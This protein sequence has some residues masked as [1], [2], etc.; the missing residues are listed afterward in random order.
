MTEALLEVRDLAKHFPVTRGLLRGK[1]IGAV[2]AVDG[3]SFRI[4]PGETFAIVGESGCGKT[5]LANLILSLVPPTHGDILLHG[6]SIARFSPAELMLY[7]K[8]VTAVF[9][10]PYGALNPRMRIGDVITEPMAIHGYARRARQQRL[11]E[12]LRAVGLSA[13]SARRFPHEFSGGQRQRVGIARAL[14]LQPPLVVLDEPVS[15]LDVSIRSQILNLLK[16]LQA[17]FGISYLLISHDLAT[18]EHMSDWIGVMYLGKLVEIG[19][20]K[21]TCRQ[22]RHPYTAT[23]VAAA[24]P[25]GRTPPWTLPIMGE[26]PHGLDIPSGCAFHPRCPYVQ[27]ICRTHTP[28]LTMLT[29]QHQVACHLYPEAMSAATWPPAPVTSA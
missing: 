7:R 14:V 13:D 9:Q 25:P 3:L 8:S 29:A 24:T 1:Q 23:L 2:K 26:V 17:E 19:Q 4:Q 22:P 21:T 28:P 27:P 11:Q 12:V 20:A 6:Q 10:D 18:V 15:S 16:D 5:T